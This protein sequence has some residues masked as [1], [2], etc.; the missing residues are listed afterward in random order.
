MTELSDLIFKII[1]DEDVTYCVLD[2]EEKFDGKPEYDY[3]NYAF[4]IAIPT[5]VEDDEIR[6]YYDGNELGALSA[7]EDDKF[8]RPTI[9]EYLTLGATLKKNNLIFNKKKKTLREKEEKNRKQIKM[10]AQ[11]R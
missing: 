5:A 9:F 2:M 3:L 8:L 1:Q 10:F 11:N 6:M 4:A 7:L